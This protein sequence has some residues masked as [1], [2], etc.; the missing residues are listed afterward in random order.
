[1]EDEEISRLN[2][3]QAE[4]EAY[5]KELLSRMIGGKLSARQY[6]LLMRM[7][8]DELERSKYEKQNREKAKRRGRDEIRN[9]EEMLESIRRHKVHTGEWPEDES[10]LRLQQ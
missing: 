6:A 4:E 5:R 8:E 1:M 7:P 9:A 2:A 10:H 3:E